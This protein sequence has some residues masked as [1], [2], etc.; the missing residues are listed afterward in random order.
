MPRSGQP[1]SPPPQHRDLKREHFS[2]IEAA[3]RRIGNVHGGSGLVSLEVLAEGLE[4]IV[5]ELRLQED[6]LADDDPRLIAAHA[7]FR[8]FANA[9]EEAAAEW[10]STARAVELTGWSTHQPCGNMP[11]D[12]SPERERRAGRTWTPPGTTWSHGWTAATTRYCW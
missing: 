1:P 8:R 9:I 6:W 7:I 2:A 3:V 11:Q 12:R 4:S 5:E 10:V